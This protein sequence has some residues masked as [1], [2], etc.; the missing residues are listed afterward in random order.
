MWLVISLYM[1]KS[2]KNILYINQIKKD[3]NKEYGVN[4][5]KENTNVIL[6]DKCVTIHGGDYITDIL[7]GVE[8]EISPHSFYQVN[9]DACELLYAKAKELAAQYVA[10]PGTSEHLTGLA[11]DVISPDWY[12]THS[13]LTGDFENTKQ[14][15]WL[16]SHCTEYG[17]I[18]RYPKGKEPITRIGYEP[19]HLRYIG[20]AEIA[21]E[22]TDKGICFEEYWKTR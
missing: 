17:F 9:H 14:F 6:G 19:W 7:C 5:N 20:S 4:I 3:Y 22:I 13:S 12:N 10:P 15:K 8:I 16:Y 2:P 18:L 1:L 21:K 11:V